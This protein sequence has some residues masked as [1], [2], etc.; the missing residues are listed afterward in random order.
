MNYDDVQEAIKKEILN[1]TKFAKVETTA[2]Q[3]IFTVRDKVNNTAIQ[4]QTNNIITK[5]DK[6]LITGLSDKNKA[7]QAPEYRAVSPYAYPSFK[8][9]KLTKE[10]ILAKK[11]PPVRLIHAS[12]YSPLYRCEKWCSPHL[13]RLSIEYCGDESLWKTKAFTYSHWM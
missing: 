5:D 6:S 3:H 12:K 10:D 8:I 13:T 4:L 9:H 2:D 1:E 7:K 11:I